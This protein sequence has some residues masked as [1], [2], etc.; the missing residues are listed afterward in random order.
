M[1]QLGEGFIN[2]S[3]GRLAYDR[4][5]AGETII[6]S[7]AGFVD[8]RMWDAQWDAFTAQYRVIRYDMLGYGASDVAN[9]PVSR[10]AH[11]AQ[12]LD[13]LQIERAH[14][15]GCSMGAE[16]TLDYA[17]EHPERVLSLTLISAAP[18]GFEM[19]GEPPPNMMEM[20]GA[21]QAGDHERASE[22]QIRLWIDGMF[23]QPEEVDAHVRQRAAEM[24]R[25]AVEN[26]TFLKADTQVF[27][28]LDPP[29]V[30]R[31][32]EISVPTLIIAGALDHPELLRAADVMAEQIPNAQKVI[33]EEAAHLPSM[34]KPGKFNETVLDF[35]SAIR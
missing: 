31:L 16:A 25:V 35:L 32:G 17:L 12:L 13:G 20:I 11:L 28:P 10:R 33:I 7:H 21:L 24:N 5:G 9:G 34:E 2:T 4:V 14:L 19:Q 8:K 29:A 3:D 22:L 15:V 27:D 23:R 26:G 30:T 6:L 18:G 1:T